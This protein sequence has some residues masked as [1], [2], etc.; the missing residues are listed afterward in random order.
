MD[1]GAWQVTSPWGHKRVG[2]DLVT[3]YART[4]TN[5]VY[6]KNKVNKTIKY[7]AIY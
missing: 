6:I 3:D 7:V 1:R 2:C 4:C 5:I